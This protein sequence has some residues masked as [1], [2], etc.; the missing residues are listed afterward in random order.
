MD[1]SDEQVKLIKPQVQPVA[2]QSVPTKEQQEAEKKRRIDEALA[3]YT[4][5]LAQ[6]GT[7]TPG[8]Q[9]N[10][11]SVSD[12]EQ[13]HNI[14]AHAHPAKSP[15]DTATQEA[16]AQFIAVH[17]DEI[18]EVLDRM[19]TRHGAVKKDAPDV[20]GEV[21]A[22]TDVDP[23]APVAAAVAELRARESAD[24]AEAAQAA[25]ESKRPVNR[26]K[27]GVVDGYMPTVRNKKRFSIILTT[28]LVAI[29]LALLLN[30]FVTNLGDGI[31]AAG[32]LII[33]YALGAYGV[34]G[35]IPLMVFYIRNS[36]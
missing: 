2:T 9:D 27:A 10:G 6:P 30:L 4:N 34:L 1:V 21:I 14:A 13:S 29:P 23:E 19:M 28:W 18:R 33:V 22:P 25:E 7:V 15:H 17:M 20:Q 12:A 16:D 32:L 3:R 35:W 26:Y 11:T 5:Q 31:F 24:A 8:S 36:L